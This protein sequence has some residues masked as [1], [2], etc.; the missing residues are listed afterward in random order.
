MCARRYCISCSSITTSPASLCLLRCR[1]FCRSSPYSDCHIPPP[2]S[3]PTPELCL[4]GLA[5][6]TAF[7]HR[8][9]PPTSLCHHLYNHDLLISLNPLGQNITASCPQ[10]SPTPTSPTL[11]WTSWKCSRHASSFSRFRHRTPSTWSCRQTS[12]CSCHFLSAYSSHPASA[13]SC[14]TVSACACR[15]GSACIHAATHNYRDL[16]LSS[17]WPYC[18]EKPKLRVRNGRRADP[19]R[20]P[21]EVFKL[22]H[23]AK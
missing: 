20:L 5:T 18:E 8:H 3:S 15:S 13:C 1:L 11:S 10:S 21:V 12:A 2:R 19:R 9:L 17:T 6:P 4:D 22:R 16:F 23:H 7:L 14:P